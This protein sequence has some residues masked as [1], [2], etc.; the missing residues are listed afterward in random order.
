VVIFTLFSVRTGLEDYKYLTFGREAI[1]NIWNREFIFTWFVLTYLA[2]P[3]VL[4]II[5]RR[6]RDKT[7]IE[8]LHNVAS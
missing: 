6:K 5:A 7:T 8:L 4:E 3:I 2:I 1:D